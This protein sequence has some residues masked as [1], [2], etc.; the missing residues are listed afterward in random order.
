MGTDGTTGVAPRA[1]TRRCALLLAMGLC[2][3][4]A[5]ASRA[6][7]DVPAAGRAA[8][9]TN[10]VLDVDFPDP[11]VI[12]APDGTFY[13]YATQGERDGAPVNIQVARS[14]DLVTWERV[15]DA[16]PTKPRWA[17]RTQD[18]WAPHVSHHEGTYYLY[19]SAKPD[20]A[21][22][23]STRGLCLAVATASR[24]E[25]PFADKGEPLQCGAGFINIDP[26]AFDDPTTGRRLLYWGSGFEAIKVQELAPDRVSFA[27]GS[28][29]VEL[30][31]PV[32]TA[33]STDYQRLVEGAWVTYR[34]PFYYLFYSGDNCCGPRAHY[35]ALVARSRS[36]T[37]P[38]QTLA[39]ATG[40][41][42]SAI[43]EQG[44]HWVAPGHNSVIRDAGG[45]DWIF[46]H[47]VDARRPR[48]DPAD[49]VNTRRVMLMDRLEYVDGWPRVDRGPSSERRPGPR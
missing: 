47:A 13:A 19:Y 42:T 10:P 37:G 23:D 38:F 22:S 30:I 28:R 24:P 25:G 2:A 32:P 40:A 27:P 46:Y 39:Q 3:C 21:L 6:P 12:R 41:R 16:L 35:A 36:A 5:P 29:P 4:T 43:L 8:T 1:M 33:D 7:S 15:G 14:A 9:Y 49:D 17:S 20:A 18:F 34:A 26:M 11:T 44:G 45:T 48:S 31:H